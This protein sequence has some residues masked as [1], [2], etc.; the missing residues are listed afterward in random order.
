MRCAWKRTPT[1]KRI[2]PVKCAIH[3]KGLRSYSLASNSDPVRSREDLLRVLRDGK[4]DGE[5]AIAI[6]RD[7]KES[8][9][10]VKL[11]PRRPARR[12]NA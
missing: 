1:L 2:G 4:E 6:V 9:V 11:E 5:L 7:R 3:G 8:T 12:G 10:T